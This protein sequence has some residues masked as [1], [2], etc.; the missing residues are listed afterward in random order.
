MN[1]VERE[2]RE[3]LERKAGSVGGVAPRLPEAVRK[4]GRRRQAGTA[5]IGAFTVAA[6]AL[7]S[8][9]GLRSIDR[10]NVDGRVPANDPWAGYEVFERTATIGNFTITSPSDWYLVNQWPLSRQ[11]AVTGETVSCSGSSEPTPAGGATGGGP[12]PTST[13]CETS[14]P[15]PVGPEV[16]PVLILSNTDLGLTTSPCFNGDV[17][18][19]DTDAVMT[20]ALDSEYMAANFGSGDRQQWPVR[21]DSPPADDRLSCGPGTYVYFASGDIPYVAHVAFGD[22]VP[23]DERQTLINAFDGMQVDDAQEVFMEEPKPDDAATYVIAGG[24]NAAGPWTLELRPQTDPG[25]VTNVQLEL[26][27]SE[28]SG[29][30][31]GGPF[32]VGEGQAIEQAGGDPVFGA[33]VVEADSVELRL[34]EGTPPVPAQLVPL[35]PSMPFGFDLFFASNPSDVPAEAVAL[36]I[37]A[38]ATISPPEESSDGSGVRRVATGVTGGTGWALD[39][40]EGGQLALG[41]VGDDILFDRIAPHHMASLSRANPML[42]GTHDFG[43]SDQPRYL[44]YGVT[45]HDVDQLSIVFGDGEVITFER[46]ALHNPSIHIFGRF[47]NTSPGVWWAEM[48]PGP[49]VAEIVAFDTACEVIA[50][51]GLALQ[52]PSPDTPVTAQATCVEGG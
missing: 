24:T 38:D 15:E 13:D 29:V 35:P 25:Y 33:V 21:F 31:A 45:H 17:L 3:L 43:S 19:G 7:V 49:V 47:P 36:G 22:A 26:S 41:G 5:A 18:V 9:A 48:P 1:D 34:E 50:R 8:F 32:T 40:D 39:Y 51:S 30:L 2:L 12:Q 11:I 14:S 44:L 10:G 20:I 42:I 6:V 4:R 16:L 23:D 27:T 52:P 37:S 28:G 46:G